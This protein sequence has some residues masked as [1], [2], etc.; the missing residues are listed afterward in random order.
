LFV[1]TSNEW[2][3][4]LTI[5]FV[6][7]VL[8]TS[9][10][11]RKISHRAFETP[12]WLEYSLATLCVAGGHTSV[13]T[14]V[15]VHRQHHRFS[16]LPKDP[17]S[18]KHRSAIGIHF[19]RVSSPPSLLYA[20]DLLRSKFYIASHKWHWLISIVVISILYL[21]D[22]MS[23]I[24]AWFTPFFLGWHIGCLVNSLNHLKIGYRNY[25]TKD[26][27]N[28]HFLTGYLAAGEGW[29]NNHHNNPANPKFGEKW[30][31]LDV[32]WWFIKLIKST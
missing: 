10:L 2:L 4:A 25:N 22:P 17:H 21:I 11:H 15:A 5:V 23:I 7:I 14:W 19:Q 29:H 13:I 16:D 20:P 12:K 31:E 18:P 24:Y 9:V 27:S 3:I 26:Q 28:N 6:R 30:W 8:T 32:G 1:G